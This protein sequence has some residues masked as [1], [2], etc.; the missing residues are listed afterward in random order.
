MVEFLY[1]KYLHFF[2]YSI[3]FFFFLNELYF[4]INVSFGFAGF[5]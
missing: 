5:V 1:L 3:N 4:I 2:F